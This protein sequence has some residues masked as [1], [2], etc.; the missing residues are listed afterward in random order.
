MGNTKKSSMQTLLEDENAHILYMYEDEE[1][2]L[3]R[4]LSY[5]KDSISAGEHILLVEN[6][7]NFQKFK[8]EL[9][10]CFST[11][12]MELLHYVNSIHFYLSSGSYYPPAIEA[13]FTNVATPYVEGEIP[14]RSWAHVEWSTLKGSTHLVEQ[15]ERIID[16][17]VHH[18]SFSLVCAYEQSR[19]SD[20]LMEL[21]LQTHPYVVE[22]DDVRIS[23]K[24]ICAFEKNS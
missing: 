15:F 5:L 12:E 14:F 22:D 19:T 3:K 17:A 4:A 13:Y 9:S 24:Y 8:E 6:E 18:Y 23:E 21:L 11:E 2:Y 7:R 10:K 16:Q 20:E 1:R